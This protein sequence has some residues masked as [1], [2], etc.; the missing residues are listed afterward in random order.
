MPI[1]KSNACEEFSKKRLYKILLKGIE[2]LNLII[3]NNKNKVKNKILTFNAICT[4]RSFTLI[5]KFL[6][7][8]I[9]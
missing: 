6:N 2:N 7:Y 1:I 4:F 3:S 9:T 8:L 5:K